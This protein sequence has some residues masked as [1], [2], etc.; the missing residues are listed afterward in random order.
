MSSVP[1]TNLTN[2]TVVFNNTSPNSTS[3]ATINKIKYF[4]L[5]KFKENI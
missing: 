2:N 5:L 1:F 3:K 4:T